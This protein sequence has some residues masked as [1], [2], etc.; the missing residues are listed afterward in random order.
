MLIHPAYDKKAFLLTAIFL[1][2]SLIG[3]IPAL[4]QSIGRETAINTLE[5]V[6][7]VRP[8]SLRLPVLFMPNPGSFGE[9]VLYSARMPEGELLLSY[10]W[11]RF[12]L[13]SQSDS[14]SS[15]ELEFPGSRQTTPRIADEADGYVNM[16]IGN[17]PEKWK[18][19]IGTGRSVIYKN[20]YRNIDLKVYA[21]GDQ[22]E[23]DWIVNPGGD[24]SRIRIR[25]KS[26]APCGLNQDG[27][28]EVKSENAKI[29]QKRPRSF[30][31][32]KGGK[33]E[34]D[35][36][37]KQTEP[38]TFSIEV[39]S[40]DKT[41]PLII[42]PKFLIYSTIFPSTAAY[43]I[44]VD[45]Q[46]FFYITGRITYGDTYITKNP[47]QKHRAGGRRA[48]TDAYVAKFAPDGQ[49]LIFSTYLGGQHGDSGH[50][51]AVA[52]DG[53]VY[54][55]GYTYSWDF[56]VKNA[57]QP[58]N[59]G[60]KGSYDAFV[61]KFSPDGT[62]LEYSTYLGG[63][64]HER[65]YDIAVDRNGNAYVTGR[66]L[67]EDF[68]TV[69]A[70]QG[71]QGNSDC[72]VSKIASGGDK[73]LLSTYL[74]GKR[75]DEATAIAVD[76]IGDIYLTGF[77]DSPNFPLKNSS[78][79]KVRGVCDAFVTKLRADG[80]APSY[81]VLIGGSITDRAY[82]IAV[83]DL[84]RAHISG[85]TY[86][87]DFPCV[88]AI[89]NHNN[90][91]ADAFIATL[92][93]LGSHLLFSTYLGGAKDDHAFGLALG[94]SR[95][96]F[97]TGRTF[98]P[99]FPTWNAYQGVYNSGLN[100][101]A[102]D[103]FIAQISENHQLSSSTFFGGARYDTFFRIA[104]NSHDECYAA[105]ETFSCGI[106]GDFPLMNPLAG[107]NKSG[108]FHDSAIAILGSSSNDF[109]RPLFMGSPCQAI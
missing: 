55:T 29:V 60:Y 107:R 65:G 67:S 53:A 72:F 48:T 93:P 88:N 34:V 70:F 13:P 40:Y 63:G 44:A 58:K 30:Q 54:V 27:G 9:E 32:I 18:T 26:D 16:F 68:P 39:S 81:S 7:P 80:S 66:T 85:A 2:M 45:S 42:D 87:A 77:T 56:P 91:G 95:S 76:K 51:I 78:Q 74:G 103:A 6:P 47:Y 86:S 17:D 99:D 14:C 57:V 106:S 97:I 5:N 50:G 96:I 61:T 101:A 36:S 1:S 94:A 84:G 23:Y 4:N 69:N 43:D 46:G 109:P 35:S 21:N 38:G 25:V 31:V 15:Y 79:N 10:N 92:S 82:D 62:S 11:I 41:T 52:R 89:Q 24:P 71:R 75:W 108:G 98:S 19:R 59:G 105:G 83:D 37:F 64:Y 73:L 22:I 104:A 90:G 102:G 8:N 28:I 49:S 33:I 3:P 20:L 12:V 100:N